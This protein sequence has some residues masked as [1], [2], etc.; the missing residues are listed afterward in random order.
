M[1]L[2]VENLTVYYQTLHGQV[3]ALEDVSFT[4]GRWRDHGL[5]R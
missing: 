2:S 1:S 4:L 5:G 3:R